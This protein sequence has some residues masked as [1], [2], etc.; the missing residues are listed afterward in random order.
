MVEMNGTTSGYATQDRLIPDERCA[1]CDTDLRLYQMANKWICRDHIA[2]TVSLAANDIW[3]NLVS[4]KR[5][6][7]KVLL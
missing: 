3:P 6:F 1:F 2:F 4:Y 5:A 7:E